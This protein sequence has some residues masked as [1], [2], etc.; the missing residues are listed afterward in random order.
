MIVRNGLAISIPV[1]FDQG[2]PDGHTVS[3][4]LYD[5]DGSLLDS[6]AVSVATDAVSVNMPIA[7]SNNTLA[8]GALF[9]SRD[10]AWSY[11]VDSN[12]INGE[13]RYS[14]EARAPFGAATDG[15]RSK[16]GVSPQDLPDDDISL[17][18]S[19]VV[20]RDTIGAD[21]LTNITDEAV[22]FAVRDAIEA[23]AALF[24]I[25]SLGTRV[26]AS[27]DT[28]TNAFKRQAIDWQVVADAMAARVNAGYVAVVPTY[29]PT[30]NAGALFVLATPATDPITNAAYTG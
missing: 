20:F 2:V 25:P 23:Q 29:D 28:G 12:I 8:N 24:A 19:Y 10:F 18:R 15:V 11:A 21:N 6:G 5:V 27:E 1:L 17:I 7:A 9:S 30:A 14:V 3:W 13:V 4:Q 22:I 26:A 16:L